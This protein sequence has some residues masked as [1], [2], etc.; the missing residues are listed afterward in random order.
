MGGFNETEEKD[1]VLLRNVEL[2]VRR[3]DGGDDIVDEVNGFFTLC[4]WLYID[5]CAS[6]PSVLLVQKQKDVTSSVP[7]LRLDE[8]KKMKLFPLLF[9][10]EGAPDPCN[11]VSW[12]ETPC[13]ST[14]FEFPIK[15]W[16]HV[17]CEVLRDFLRLY[18]DGEI[19]GEKPLTCSI[20]VYGKLLE[21]SLLCQRIYLAY[22]R[23]NGDIIHGYVHGL[24]LVLPAGVVKN[25][26]VKD[27][28]VRLLI[29]RSS[30]SGIEE[31]S[32]GVWSIVGGKASCRRS[33]SVDIKLL[34]AFDSSVNKELEVVASLLYADNEAPVE[35]TTDAEPPILTSSDGIEYACYDRPCKLIN[36]RA[37][38]KLKISQLSSKCE[39]RLFRI[40]FDIPKLG[41]K[42]PFLETLSPSICCVSRN[43]NIR[44]APQTCRKPLS[45]GMS[46]CDFPCLVNGT[47]EIVQNIVREAKPSPLSKR[48]KLGNIIPFGMLKEDMK[49]A[50]NGHGYHAWTS[51]EDNTH[52]MSAI[53]MIPENHYSGAENNSFASDN[54]ESTNSDPKNIL[55][56]SSPISDVIIFKYCLGGP[57][58]RCHIL[59]EIAISAS[60]EQLANFAEQVSLFSG[61]SHHRRQ[62]K[63]SK[64]LVE[65]GIRV[66]TSI[67]ENNNRVLWEN[68]IFRI[69]EHFMKIARSSR[70]LTEQDFEC[71]RRI[72]GCRDLVPQEDFE[73]LWYWLYPVA[74]TL[75][76]HAVNSMWNSMSPVWMQGFITKEE[77]ESALQ[78]PGTF[79]LRFPTSRSWPHPDAGN[80]VVTYVGFDRRIHHRLLSLDFANR[81]MLRISSEGSAVKP[82]QELLLQEP[83]LSR[84]GKMIRSH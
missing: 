63:I 32:D 52:G 81:P 36:G 2:E 49:L 55:S 18:V 41:R 5:S 51:Y 67:P 33:F 30:A 84:L 23:E 78:G 25:H 66:W 71:L 54:T 1:Y 16:V 77:A 7:F 59:R 75:S 72:A 58:E 70:S 53:R 40:K 22:P 42:Y 15:K 62:I 20:D 64:K 44:T 3:D 17:G 14:E 79:V 76:R 4:F 47:A 74:F 80:L 48:V 83:E 39:N 11:T 73:R 19:V 69:N 10:H 28:P 60:E 61:C 68:L 26:Y 45:N 27:P 56:I 8:K 37:S 35:N 57:S 9:L 29:D 13:A 46:R 50:N 65:E 43:K 21:R 6:F 38:F 24:D 31:D 12:K 82:L 34:D